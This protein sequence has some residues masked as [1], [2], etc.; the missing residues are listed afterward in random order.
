MSVVIFNVPRV[1]FPG[2][3]TNSVFTQGPGDLFGAS[4]LYC[5]YFILSRQFKCPLVQLI[6]DC[7][8]SSCI[9]AWLADSIQASQSVVLES[10]DEL[11]VGWLRKKRHISWSA[12][13]SHMSNSEKPETD[14]F[15][16]FG[17]L[18]QNTTAF[19][20]VCLN[21]PK[22]SA[23]CVWGEWRTVIFQMFLFLR[24][25]I[26]VLKLF[27]QSNRLPCITVGTF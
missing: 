10:T 2:L 15:S 27:I 24:W 1:L 20:W 13:G 11:T 4:L 26:T 12:K 8:H 5:T 25:L 23:C 19:L 16:G 22:V 17:L 7:E 18:P 6:K 14:C 21:K 3:L 9:Y